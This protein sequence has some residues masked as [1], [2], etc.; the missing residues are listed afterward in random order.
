V[1]ACDVHHAPLLI[2]SYPVQQV[3]GGTVTSTSAAAK[4]CWR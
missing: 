2:R 1:H 4:P 3:A